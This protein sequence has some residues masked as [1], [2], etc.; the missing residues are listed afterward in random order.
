M[1]S[2]IPY[3]IADHEYRSNHTRVICDVKR[4]H[5]AHR[6][7]R[8]LPP[9]RIRSAK[10]NI[11]LSRTII[12]YNNKLRRAIPET[13][14]R[15][16][17]IS[18]TPPDRRCSGNVCHSVDVLNARAKNLDWKIRRAN[19]QITAEYDNFEKALCKTHNYNIWT[20]MAEENMTI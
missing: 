3:T 9:R 10:R 12:I 16:C 14:T 13:D 19:A 17:S 5:F 18:S 8:R 1:W 6:D 15:F 11:K 2:S 7:S 20:C 4:V